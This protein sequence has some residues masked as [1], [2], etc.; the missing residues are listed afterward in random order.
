MDFS[1]PQP[2]GGSQEHSVEQ[3]KEVVKEYQQYDIYIEFPDV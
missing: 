1:C 2:V 3:Q